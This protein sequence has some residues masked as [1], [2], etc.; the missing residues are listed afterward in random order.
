[1]K[2]LPLIG[3]V[4]L[5]AMMSS[6]ATAQTKLTVTL[7]TAGQQLA[8]TLQL[9]ESE[10]VDQL[11]EAT[12]GLYG[13]G[14]P[15]RLLRRLA[16]GQSLTNRG[17]GVDYALTPSI[18]VVGAGGAIA[19][20][21]DR[22]VTVNGKEYDRALPLEAAQA[23]FMAGVNLAQIPGVELPFVLSVNTISLNIAPKD[24]WSVSTRSYGVHA[25]YELLDGED[26][27]WAARW[28][29]LVLTT[30]YE[31]SKLQLMVRSNLVYSTELV[32]TGVKIETNS[33][34]RAKVVQ[35]ANTIPIEVSSSFTAAYVFT[36][37][38]ALGVDLQFGKARVDMDLNSSIRDDITNEHSA[39]ASIVSRWTSRA[40]PAAAHGMLGLQLN[41]YLLKVYIQGA[42][43]TT[44]QLA[45]AGG[46]RVAY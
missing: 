21:P 41:L 45:L 15:N 22:T 4:A 34:G 5:A 37:Y 2:K 9:S 10:L 20:R 7:T 27:T 1:M 38:G 24:S 8:Q 17:L 29:G 44:G 12:S 40:S 6:S 43:A 30:G 28:S 18:V 3:A 16:N 11:K 25:Q 33:S 36:F 23:S 19:R 31:Y 13:L 35:I 14:A 42:Y 26:W 39:D 46:A 32:D